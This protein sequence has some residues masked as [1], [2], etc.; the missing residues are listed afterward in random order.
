MKVQVKSKVIKN[1][2]KTSVFQQ[3]AF[4]AQVKRKHGIPSKAFDLKVDASDLY[5]KSTRQSYILDDLLIL[6]PSIDYDYKIAYVPHG[7]TVNPSEENQGIF[8]EELSESL[9][10]YLPSKC[11]M[12]RYDLLW[13]SPWA[14]EDFY[15]NNDGDWIGPPPKVNQE[16]RLNF[17]TQKWNLKKANTNILPSDTIFLDLKKDTNQLLKEMKPK[18]RY[19][20]NLSQRKGVR[21]RRT[22]INDLDIW[23][24]LYQETCIRNRI[25]LQDIEYFQAVLATKTSDTKSPAEVEL[26]IAEI[27]HTPLAAMFLVFSG[28]R[29][30]YLYGASSSI[31]RNYMPTY[32]LQWDA[33][34]RAKNRGCTEYDMFG[35]APKPDHAHPLYGLYRFK[36]GFGGNLFH[37]MGCWD[38][39]FNESSYKDYLT[40]E[41]KSQGY[42]LH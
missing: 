28:Q 23:Y 3:T 14:K 15:F 42:H 5:T 17:D 27:D 36:K 26:L 20:I 37:R 29:A 21:V 4:W 7:P 34:K 32:A 9:R 13:E 16:M 38:Y 31:K 8:L 6:F 35:V 39:P 11:L 30:T 2:S 33:I 10:P 40:A 1:I 24:K 22:D 18:T 12:L 25:Y 19:N 41:M